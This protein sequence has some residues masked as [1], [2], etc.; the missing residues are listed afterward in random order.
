MRSRQ[1]SDPLPLQ[2]KYFGACIV[3]ILKTKPREIRR[4]DYTAPPSIEQSDKFPF[5]LSVPP[6]PKQ[7]SITL[8]G[9]IPVPIFV[10]RDKNET[11][12]ILHR[13]DQ[14]PPIISGW[15]HSALPRDVVGS[16]QWTD[17]VLHLAHLLGHH[18]ATDWLNDSDKPGRFNACHAEKKL[19]A[20]FID[21]HVFLPS[22]KV[23]SMSKPPERRRPDPTG[24]VERRQRLHEKLMNLSRIEPKIR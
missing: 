22:D 14:Y 21:R 1:A 7:P 5:S 3:S 13:G 10:L 23:P 20:C 16:P 15:G 18:L 11:V 12:A 9:P 2:W 6:D 8:Q 4:Q 19:I 17:Q 24:R